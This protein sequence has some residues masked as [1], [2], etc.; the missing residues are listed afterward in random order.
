MPKPSLSLL[1][2]S[3][4]VVN[5]VKLHYSLLT[6]TLVTSSALAAIDSGMLHRFRYGLALHHD[7]PVTQVA[8]NQGNSRREYLDARDTYYDDLEERDLVSSGYVASVF[9]HL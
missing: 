9:S 6:L 7:N 5:M 4:T 1:N 2:L 3:L 8:P